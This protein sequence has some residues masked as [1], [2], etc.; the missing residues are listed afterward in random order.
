[1]V[2]ARRIS[3][4]ISME[5]LKL[6]KESSELIEFSLPHKMGLVLVLLGFAPWGV[7]FLNKNPSL[8]MPMTLFSGT[9]VL[10]GL[11]VW[12]RRHRFELFPEERMFQESKGIWPRLKVESG[13]YTDVAGTVLQ[14]KGKKW[15][16]GLAK[17]LESQ[18]LFFFTSTHEK[19]A[20]H[21][22]ERFAKH[23]ECKA[24]DHSNPDEVLEFNWHQ[25]GSVHADDTRITQNRAIIDFDNPPPGTFVE[26]GRKGFR[27][28]LD[29]RGFR[30]RFL[31]LFIFGALL[32]VGG[33]F[34]FS[35]TGDDLTENLTMVIGGLGG[36]TVGLILA[37]TGAAGAFGR[38]RIM[39][40]KEQV[41]AD[42]VFLSFPFWTKSIPMDRIEEIIVQNKKLG[43]TKEEESEEVRADLPKEILI[44]SD[45]SRI[46]FG[47]HQDQET[48]E[49]VRTAL[50]EYVGDLDQAA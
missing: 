4:S 30:S 31:G 40:Y 36:F 16:V 10:F 9:M 22:F 17:D 21:E 35:T 3:D 19:A 45:F 11:V 50:L 42:T 6:S 18:P 27:V 41:H 47:S 38:E 46:V 43:R 29:L 32:M 37:V 26:H 14:K 13:A 2:S 5:I 49:W 28:E 7:Y 1:M 44:R 24:Y 15:L 20:R 48:L 34:L 39:F 12:A 25:L 8:F 33:L 23:L